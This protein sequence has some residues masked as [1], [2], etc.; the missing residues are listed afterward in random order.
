[1]LV[2]DKIRAAV[3]LNFVPCLSPFTRVVSVVCKFLADNWTVKNPMLVLNI[4]MLGVP[5]SKR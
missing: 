2:A 4:H 3:D 1:L 5:Q